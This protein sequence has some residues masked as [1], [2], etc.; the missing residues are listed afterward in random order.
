MPRRIK[1]AIVGRPN[2]G[3]SALFNCIVKKSISIVDE[4]EGVTRDRIYGIADYFGRPIEVIDTGGMLAQEDPLAKDITR[5][6]E[7][8]V[9]EADGL[10]FVVDSKIGPQAID[11]E[12]AKLI[13]KA[14][15]PLVLAINKVDSLSCAP[16]MVANFSSLGIQPIVAISCSHKFQ[17]AEL[18]EAL[19]P[20]ISVPENELHENLPSD[21]IPVALIGRPN[22][23][24]SSLLNCI[25][26]QERSLVS[27]IP[28]TTRDS[29][30][31]L[32]S[33]EDHR[34][35]FIDTAGIKRRQK[36]RDVIE[37]FAHIRT[38]RAIERASICLLLV[39]CQAGVTTEEKK[40]A[41]EIEEAKKGCILLL[42]KWDLVKGFRM[43]H[44]LKSIEEEI[45]F[46]ATCPKLIISAKS[47]RNVTK[48]FPLIQETHAAYC[49]RI[50]THRLNKALIRWMQAYHPPMV[51]GKRLRIYYMSQ[52]SAEPP[53]FVLFVNG[54]KHFDEGYKKYLINN[55]RK[56]FSFHGVPIQLMIR[57]KEERE[58]RKAPERNR[59][60][61]AGKAIDRDLAYIEEKVK[62]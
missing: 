1:I 37:K 23:G 38:E 6:A 14:K 52:I 18:L 62:E 11:F 43:E 9:E 22:V 58:G 47:G 59:P 19:I 31:S 32:F 20:Q 8:A 33:S 44:A 45:P 30:D 17:I 7:I 48:I 29:I 57:G 34:F 46:L 41:S 61:S 21:C 49:R 50:S 4:S 12:V 36:E 13:R 24:K 26:G 60:S 54:K 2:V 55:L 51:G 27:P 5:Q 3:K 35:L 28:G 25:S 16:S 39:D 53:S 42:N 40:I 10:I 15:K 56:E